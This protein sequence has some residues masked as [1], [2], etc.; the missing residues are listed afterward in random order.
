M[1][2]WRD[3]L[4]IY[5]HHSE[6]QVITAL[7]LISTLYKSPQHPLGPSPAR[8]VFISQSL[9]TASNSGD[10]SASR[11]KVILSQ[12]AAHTELN[13]TVNLTIAPSILRL[14]CRAQLNSLLQTVLLITCQHGPHRKHRFH[15]KSIVRCVYVSAGRVFQAVAQKRSLYIRLLRSHCIATVIVSFASRSLPSNG[16]TRHDT[17]ITK[18]KKQ[19]S[20]ISYI[21]YHINYLCLNNTNMA[22]MCPLKLWLI[23]WRY[24]MNQV[25]LSLC[26]IS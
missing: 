1:D 15:S 14:S 18:H 3:L 19:N 21:I 11:A 7:S 24:F 22:K 17:N 5:T 10:Y 20:Y 2:W 9:A 13:S 8:C 12:P 4:T 25:T 16:S 23:L 26:L 6:L